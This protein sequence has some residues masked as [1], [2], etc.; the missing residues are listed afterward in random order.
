MHHHRYILSKLT[1]LN[2]HDF[3]NKSSDTL[4]I[5]EDTIYTGSWTHTGTIVIAPNVTLTFNKLTATIVGDIILWGKNARFIVDSSNL[6][7]PQQYFYQRSLLA[8][9]NSHIIIN[10]STLN[11]SNLSHNLELLFGSTVEMVNVNNIGFTTNGIWDSCS[12]NIN[13]SN[14]AG[15]YITTEWAKLKFQNAATILLWHQFPDTAV[16]NYSFPD[17]ASVKSYTFNNTI[18]GIKGIGYNI[19]VTNC[20]D[21]MWGMMPANGSNVT[22]SNS[23]IRSIGLWF[24]GKDTFNLSGLVDY[25]TYTDFTA[26]LKDRNLHLINSSVTTW[27]LYPMNNTWLNVTGSILGEVVPKI[28]RIS[29]VLN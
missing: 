4:Y 22:I 15:E 6:Y 21:V 10:N 28:M 14:Q 1:Y 27:S 19:N 3:Q 16:I 25:S 8:V 5:A 12:V 11:Y 2:H 29:P 18:P 26:P 9:N 20:T 7:F 24:T 17:G 23:Q 13:G